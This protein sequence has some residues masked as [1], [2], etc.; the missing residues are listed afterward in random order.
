MDDFLYDTPGLWRHGLQVA[1]V[2]RRQIL[3]VPVL[4]SHLISEAAVICDY[5]MCAEEIGG[6][7][8]H[9]F[10][11]MKLRRL[12]LHNPYKKY[13]LMPKGVSSF[14]KYV[15]AA[16]P[17]DLRRD[18]EI[19]RITRWFPAPDRGFGPE[20]SEINNNHCDITIST[21]ASA[22]ELGA[23]VL[24]QFDYIEKKRHSL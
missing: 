6:V 18:G 7:I 23:F 14:K 3:F 16:L 17:V 21:S 5:P 19:F 13:W 20:P 9:F 8:Y 1:L 4:R 11:Q 22:E 10:E 15:E 12:T 2:N 24:Q